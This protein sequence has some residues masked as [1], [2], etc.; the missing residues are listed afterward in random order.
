MTEVIVRIPG[1]LRSFA[2]GA[3]QLLAPAGTVAEII[4][5]LGER[6]PQLPTRLLTAEG[7]LRPHVNIFIGR[8]NVRELQ[9]LASAVAS[10]GTVSILPAVAGG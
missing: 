8:E 5:F 4:R 10:G 3:E 9:G 6:H 1:P 2:G 7:E